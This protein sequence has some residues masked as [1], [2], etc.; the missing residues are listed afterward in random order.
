MFPEMCVHL[1][2]G[3]YLLIHAYMMFINIRGN[4]LEENLMLPTALL[5]FKGYQSTNDWS[6]LTVD[7]CV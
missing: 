3:R 4:Q 6:A 5:F 1:K 7:V 2:E